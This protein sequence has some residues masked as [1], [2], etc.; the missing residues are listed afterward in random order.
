MK[1]TQDQIIELAKEVEFTDDIDWDNLP[2]EKDKIYQMV[3]SQ[4]IELYEKYSLDTDSEKAVLL[5]T[6]TKLVVENFV[7]NLRVNSF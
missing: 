5:A 4:V 7:L 1:Y 3:G 6:I 2:L